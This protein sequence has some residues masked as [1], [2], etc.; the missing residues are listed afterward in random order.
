M[1]GNM[2]LG[3]EAKDEVIALARQVMGDYYGK[4]VNMDIDEED[5]AAEEATMKCLVYKSFVVKCYAQGDGA[6]RFEVAIG[7]R[8]YPLSTLLLQGDEL[9]DGGDEA[10]LRHDVE[11]LDRYLRFRLH[12]HQKVLLGLPLR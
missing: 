12:D 1:G 6:T 10:A 11:V 4:H 2:K 9:S 7:D 5:D 8:W 3:N